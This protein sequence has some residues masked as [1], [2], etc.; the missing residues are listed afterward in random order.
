MVF[1]TDDM[2]LGIGGV[3][4]ADGSLRG[5]LDAQ[6]AAT[7][8]IDLGS[9]VTQTEFYMDG[10][11][12]EAH[13]QGSVVTVEV[14]RGQ[15]LWELTAKTPLPAPTSIVRTEAMD[16]AARIFLRPSAAATSYRVEL[17]RDD[18]A[19]WGKALDAAQTTCVLTGLTN[20]IK[21][22]VRA[23]AA[24]S[25]GDSG[26]CAEYSVYVTHE[27]PMPP[28]GMHMELAEGA[29][30][31]GWGEVLGVTEYRLYGRAAGE[32]EFR[33]LYRGLERSFTDRRP[34]IRPC[35]AVPGRM[36]AKGAVYGTYYVTACNGNGESRPSRTVDTDPSSWRNWDPKPGERFRR[37]YSFDPESPPSTSEFAR[38]YPE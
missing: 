16:G 37:V 11:K 23:I 32:S 14:G 28:D 36:P 12:S 18:G 8:Q 1:T 5:R 26:A 38:Y 29:A 35:D 30:T 9:L 2:D 3:L 21:V 17:S 20:G 6:R 7:V 15:F 24:N 19:T 4:D 27:A 34:G 22:H 31:V 10:V 33:V 25:R 13:R